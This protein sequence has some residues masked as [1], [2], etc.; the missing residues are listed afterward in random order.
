M[1]GLAKCGRRADTSGAGLDGDFGDLDEE[2]GGDPEMRRGC[3]GRFPGSRKGTGTGMIQRRR[4]E[5]G[6]GGDQRE[7]AR[8][9]EDMDV[10][11]LRG[12]SCLLW[13]GRTNV[14]EPSLAMDKG[15]SHVILHRNVQ[16]S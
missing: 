8:G 2:V 3:R 9:R 11:C 6:G 14:V 4:V 12:T 10:S 7:R 16:L 5:W 13:S 15:K 1:P